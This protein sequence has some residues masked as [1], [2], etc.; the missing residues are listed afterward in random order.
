[1]PETW[2]TGRPIA[3]PQPTPTVERQPYYWPSQAEVE[4]EQL[5]IKQVKKETTA[6][7]DLVRHRFNGQ[8]GLVIGHNKDRTVFS[9]KIVD[10]N[11]DPHLWPRGILYVGDALRWALIPMDHKYYEKLAGIERRVTWSER[12]LVGYQEKKPPFYIA[13]AEFLDFKP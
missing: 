9:I 7:G 5:L 12:D 11:K 6:I 10:F 3:K 2:I 13:I 8:I 1:M 4:N